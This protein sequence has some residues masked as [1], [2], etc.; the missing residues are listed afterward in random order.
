MASSP[1]HEGRAPV[2]LAVSG[3]APWGQ[4]PVLPLAYGPSAP[5]EERRRPPLGLYIH[6]HLA[7][8]R[9]LREGSERW[10][11]SVAR[12]LEEAVAYFGWETTLDAIG[13]RDVEL[14]MAYLLTRDNGRGGTLSPGTVN[15]YISSLSNLLRRA[16]ND[17]LI[18]RNP[19]SDLL[20]RPKIR[21][22]RTPW[23]EIPELA[24]ILHAARRY[25]PNPLRPSVPFAFEILATFAYAGLR[26]VELYGLEII[27]VNL[28]R[29][30]ILVRANAWRGLKNG[31]SDR[32]V[33]IFPE[34]AAI[35][36][37]YLSGP[38][39][40]TR[41]LL[42]PS[43]YSSPARE[44]RLV[45]LRGLFDAMPMPERLRRLCTPAELAAA[46]K[47][48]E[49]KLERARGRRSGPKPTEDQ[50]QLLLPIAETRVP[51]L[52]SRILRHSYCAA[53]LQTLDHGSPIAEYTV[54]Q[55]MG[56]TDWRMV[57]EIYGHL[58]NVR[59]RS[60][61]VEILGA[62]S[63]VRRSPRRG[64][65]MGWLAAVWRRVRA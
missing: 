16:I 10:L 44:R 17:G 13:V 22:A 64:D 23:L 33:P 2:H 47:T 9:R 45:N 29:G 61:H 18:E 49:H 37:A 53:R 1:E 54:A 59:R 65:L 43:P 11:H 36:R 20:A 48:R 14:Y 8:K 24:L 38:L 63:A 26:E 39:A 31:E 19:V 15:H 3:S 4:G 51:P 27:D 21:R 28:E 6:E 56:H 40:P 35:L 55:E 32:V 5:R 46:E 41:R 50:E 57:H 60:E 25:Q 42:F 34:L 62:V 58:S 7:L 30:I 52:R 12:H